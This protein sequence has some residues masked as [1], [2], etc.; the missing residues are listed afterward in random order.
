MLKVTVYISI[1]I[2]FSFWINDKKIF[3]IHLGIF[4]SNLFWLCMEAFYL[5]NYYQHR[6]WTQWAKFKSWNWLFAFHIVLIPLGKLW[7]HLFS[8][9]PAKYLD[10]LGSLALRMASSLGEAK[11][12]IS[13]VGQNQGL[14]SLK[15]FDD[16]FNHM[17]LVV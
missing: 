3:K 16:V 17:P 1:W 10:I 12:V 14:E 8:L 6:K 4:I 15:Q 7:I 5:Q 13:V 2:R 9:H 11:L